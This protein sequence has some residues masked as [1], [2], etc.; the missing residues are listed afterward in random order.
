MADQP[1]QSLSMAD[2]ATTITVAVTTSEEETC[3][4]CLEAIFS[5]AE[6]V[7]RLPCNHRIHLKC[8]NG[9][10]AHGY[11]EC[12]LCRGPMSTVLKVV[13]DSVH[14]AMPNAVS[15]VA[16]MAFAAESTDTYHAHNKDLSLIHI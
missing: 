15:T 9:L 16:A 12:P 14:A 10:S 3:C 8:A 6:E 5:D 4:I 11:T 2:A 1:H 7:L 13:S